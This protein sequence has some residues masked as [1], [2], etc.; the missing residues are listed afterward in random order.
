MAF[1]ALLTH[2][3]AG[4]TDTNNVTTTGIDTT[5]A[6][7]IVAELASWSAI[8]PTFT[9]SKGNSWTALSQAGDIGGHSYSKLYYCINPTSVGA[10]HTFTASSTSGAPSINVACFSGGAGNFD[11]QAVAHTVDNGGAVVLSTGTITPTGSNQLVITG[12]ATAVTNGTTI[13]AVDGGFTITDTV[14]STAN[15]SG[16]GLAY[17]IQTTIAAANPQWTTAGAAP[18]QISAAVASFSLK[19]PSMF[20]VF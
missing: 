17:L 13:T 11:Q 4:S 1:Y 3:G 12:V 14:S 5:G 19:V 7:I 10:A 8:D 18:N 9:D 15:C 6:T 2:T 20:M 16:G